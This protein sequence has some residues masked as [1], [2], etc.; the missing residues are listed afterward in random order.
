M[1]QSGIF[2]AQDPGTI[3]PEYTF[4]L[5]QRDGK[6][7]LQT[8]L[9]PYRGA[10]CSSPGDL[11][12]FILTLT[13]DLPRVTVLA[14]EPS[15]QILTAWST[16]TSCSLP[17]WIKCIIIFLSS[18]LSILGFLSHADC[19]VVA[20]IDAATVAAGVQWMQRQN[21]K[22]YVR[23]QGWSHPALLMMYRWK[24]RKFIFLIFHL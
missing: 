15:K 8:W 9:F 17:C 6:R 19:A 24:L 12:V 11:S 16:A 20:D 23:C 14:C 5:E 3:L 18:Q 13:W 10:T 2:I 4:Q 22:V 1:S 7:D 21:R